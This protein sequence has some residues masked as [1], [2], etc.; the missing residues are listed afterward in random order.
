M[1]LSLSKINKRKDSKALL[2]LLEYQIIRSLTL[3]PSSSNQFDFFLM[4]LQKAK[5]LK[6]LCFSNESCSLMNDENLIKLGN[7][8][9]DDKLQISQLS[10][11]QSATN[12]DSVVQFIKFI[13]Q[14]LAKTLTSFSLGTG[15]KSNLLIITQ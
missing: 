9:S 14:G 10:V 15:F 8:L 12:I 5:F 11:S 6:D 4:G 1:K 13:K 2:R 3:S 7:V